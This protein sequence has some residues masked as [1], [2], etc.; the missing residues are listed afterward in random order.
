MIENNWAQPG[1][2][3]IPRHSHTRWGKECKIAKVYKNGNFVLEGGVQQYRPWHEGTAHRTGGGYSS[4][5]LYHLT[6]ELREKIAGDRENQ[7]RADRLQALSEAAQRAARSGVPISDDLNNAA[8]AFLAAL[9]AWK[10]ER[11]AKE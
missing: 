11:T 5:T 4:T 7:D 10:D 3:V 9:K 8:Q 6:D 2:T 1:V